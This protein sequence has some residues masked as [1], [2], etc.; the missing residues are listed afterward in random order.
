MALTTVEKHVIK[1]LGDH[2]YPLSY[3]EILTLVPRDIDGKLVYK[4][5][6]NLVDNR[7]L[8]FGPATWENGTQARTWV[9]TLDG[10]FVLEGIDMQGIETNSAPEKGQ[11]KEVIKPKQALKPEAEQAAA[12]DTPSLLDMFDDAARVMRMS[13]EASLSTPP[14]NGDKAEALA[15]I[16]K[17]LNVAKAMGDEP[18][19]KHF[20]DITSLLMQ[21]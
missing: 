9:L 10:K 8:E 21:L 2:A 18:A 19:Q 6:E 4:A 3:K 5:L 13:I 1:I 14:F 7:W 11:G 17:Y 16:D 15:T 12:Q 20:S